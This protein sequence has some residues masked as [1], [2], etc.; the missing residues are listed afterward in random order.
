MKRTKILATVGP[1][2]ES[3]EVLAKL[4]EAGLDAAR[5]NFSHGTADDHRKRVK[6]I[7]EGSPS[8]PVSRQ[9]FVLGNYG[10]IFSGVLNF[11]ASVPCRTV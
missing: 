5:C 2:S 9:F 4:F 11:D 6:L 10:I 3:E 1:A 7:R 8:L